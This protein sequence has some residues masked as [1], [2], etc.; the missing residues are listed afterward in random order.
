MKAV[1]FKEKV[2]TVVGVAKAA[3]HCRRS[4]QHVSAVAKGIRNGSEQVH[5]AIARFCTVIKAK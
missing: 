4:R 3:R 2:T 5:S 1:N